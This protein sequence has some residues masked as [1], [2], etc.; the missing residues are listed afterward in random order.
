MDNNIVLNRVF[1]QN[2]LKQ[3][4][5]EKQ[6][7]T[8]L[9]VIRRYL[10]D[11]TSKDYNKVLSEIYQYMQKNYRNE[12]IYKNTLLNKLLLGLHKPTTTVALSEIPIS[13]SK[14][15]FVL[16]NGKAVVYEIK[17]ELDTF[18]R[19]ST[20]LNDYYKAF[21]HVCVLTSIK[22]QTTISDILKESPVG[23]YLLTARNQIRVLKK[24][25]KYT[26][27]LDKNEIFKVLNK[28]EFESVIVKAGYHL[29]EVTPVK[30]YSEC[31]KI[32]NSIDIDLLYRLYLKELKRRNRI[33]LEQYYN[34]PYE[35]KSLVY[36]SKYRE[37]DY[38]EL[39]DLLNCK[40]EG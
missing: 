29:P 14:A 20:Q 12:Y 11:P 8:V 2:T 5:T 10:N 16:I 30:Y 18:E 19:L 25:E 35:L 37:K 21:D 33:V 28:K 31:R 36:F 9:T 32:I 3:L 1:T 4:T 38:K 6:S 7:E 40:V 27:R 39:F 24:P 34:V 23:I 26:E 13:K 17:T 15:D 22:N